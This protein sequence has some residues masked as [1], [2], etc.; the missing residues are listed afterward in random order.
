[1]NNYFTLIY[2]IEHIKFKCEDS[3]FDFSYSPHKDVWEGYF[4]KNSDGFRLIL[5]TRFN[6]TALFADSFRAPKK[7]NV[8]TFF[9]SL[10]GCRVLDVKLAENDRFVSI[11]FDNK[12]QLQFQL[13]GH[14]ANVHLIDDGT[15]TDAFKNPDGVKGST[16][17]EPRSPRKPP[18][19]NE[20][21]SAKQAITKTEPKFPRHL[22]E[23]VIQY[24][25][26]DDKPVEDV[27]STTRMLVD[28]MLKNPEY[29]VL[30]NGNICLVPTEILPLENDKVFDDCNSAVRY[31]YYNTSKKRRLTS[32]FQSIAPKL[33]SEIKKTRSAIDQLERADKALERAEKY[34]QY[35]HILMAHAHE[36][37]DQGTESIK[38][39]D[40]YDQ[41]SEVS[42]D[43]KPTLSLAENAQRYYEKS[44]NAKK[45][46]TES[47]RRLANE[48]EKI[49]RLE[50]IEKSFSELDK[51]YEFDDW[52]DEHRQELQELGVL[53]QNQQKEVLPF[54]RATIDGYEIWIGK[55][56]KSNDEVTIR[57][58][59]EDIWLHA[60]GVGGSHVVIR[61]NNNKD[62]P[63]KQTLLKVAAV[64][65]WNSK[66]RGSS[67]APV[68]ITKRK[69]VNKSKKLPPGAV[70]VQKEQVEMVKPHPIK[71]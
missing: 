59:K 12:K 13:F 17:P 34:E 53:S 43:L 45:R 15:I 26:L 38:L 60:R 6:E 41:N 20:K 49:E 28:N 31:T 52:M 67:L 58:H 47:K 9:E 71:S 39:P 4:S 18:S 48:Q 61:M 42:I 8:T 1:M 66:A 46:V 37:I 27:A 21:W 30:E 22:T 62:M 40:L 68:I 33:E 55:N 44:S 11:T 14:G 57:A 23:P 50:N 29:R 69:Y 65:A 5:S 25:N 16:P 2:L 24:F 10:S 7:S 36:T 32:R 3:V 35:G 51:I 19:L 70:H 56:A 64:A 63:Q 54:R